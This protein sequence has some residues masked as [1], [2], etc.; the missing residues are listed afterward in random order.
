[1]MRHICTTNRNTTSSIYK[2]PFS[3]KEQQEDLP[4]CHGPTST[5]LSSRSVV[6]PNS[7]C[8]LFVRNLCTSSL[9]SLY[10]EKYLR[11]KSII[12]QIHPKLQR[13]KMNKEHSCCK[14]PTPK[15]QTQLPVSC[16]CK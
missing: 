13:K 3:E 5:K 8:P 4:R 11:I 12:A 1:M 2:W 7:H 14:G 6:I 15:H 16:T 10:K 9:K